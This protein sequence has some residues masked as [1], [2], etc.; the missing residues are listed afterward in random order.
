MIAVAAH[1]SRASSR[2]RELYVVAALLA[3]AGLCFSKLTEDVV[4]REAIVRH[5]RATAD[6][7][8]DH[9]SHGLTRLASAVTELGA[10]HTVLALALVAAVVLIARGRRPD[11]TLVLAS[12]VGGFLLNRLIKALVERPRPAL[13]DRLVAAHGFSFPS[14]HTMAAVTLYGVLAYLAARSA[15]SARARVAIGVA[16]TLVMATVG[17]S[18]MVLGVHYLSDVLAA[19]A[20]GAAWLLVCLL[21]VR[22]WDTANHARPVSVS[23][24]ATKRFSRSP[25]TWWAG[26]TRSSSSTMRN[27]E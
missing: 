25:S 12:V 9:A 10:S 26:S 15:R 8:R 13:H 1:W 18:R 5:D 3:L 23:A 27:A 4:E 24:T 7:L 20:A 21:A 19:L 17:A 22:L 2:V 14:G 11:A 6:W 16:A